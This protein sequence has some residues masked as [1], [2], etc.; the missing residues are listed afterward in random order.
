MSGQPAAVEFLYEL[1]DA[2]W[3]DGPLGNYRILRHRITK[4]TARRIYFVR[5]G[6]RP[7]FVDRQRMEAAGEIFY[8]P[9]ARTLYLAEPTLPRQ[10]KPA[11]LPELKAAMADAHP[12]RGGT[13][14]AFIA[15][16]QRYERA[17]TLP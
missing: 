17:R 6:D 14:S 11:S 12:D 2:N 10:P 13:N 7:A 15:A 9:I 16:R 3:D 4:K 5:C 8:R 1:W